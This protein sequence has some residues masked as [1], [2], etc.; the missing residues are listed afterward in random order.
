MNFATEWQLARVTKGAG[1]PKDCV[2]VQAAFQ[3]NFFFVFKL[4]LFKLA[5]APG[6]SFEAT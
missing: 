6:R 2:K 4:C 5:T 1:E 3:Q